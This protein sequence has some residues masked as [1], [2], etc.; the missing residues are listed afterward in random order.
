MLV[1]VV[2][3]MLKVNKKLRV[4]MVLVVRMKVMW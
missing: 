2:G 3:R 4:V 1:S